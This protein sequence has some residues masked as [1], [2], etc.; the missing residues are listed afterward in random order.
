MKHCEDC[1]AWVR[2]I[3]DI[4]QCHRR[5]PR[6]PGEAQWPETFARH[7]CLEFVPSEEEDDIPDG[8]YIRRGGVWIPH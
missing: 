2:H 7:G 1:A 8:L 6:E 3:Q 4:G 5:A